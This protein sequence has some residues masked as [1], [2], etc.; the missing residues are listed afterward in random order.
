MSEQLLTSLTKWN[1]SR[2]LYSPII[3][4]KNRENNNTSAF[5]FL[6]CSSVLNIPYTSS[7]MSILSVFFHPKKS[8]SSTLFTPAPSY[9]FSSLLPSSFVVC[10][11]SST[12][13]R[14]ILNV[15][16]TSSF[17]P[18]LFFTSFFLL[19]SVTL[20]SPE[21]DESSKALVLLFLCFSSYL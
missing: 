15:L 5:V 19:L 4:T 7:F 12:R 21:L 14:L 17:I 20:L 6:G 2:K 8:H 13:R 18:I 16:Y 9:L 1:R 10:L 3:T 11:S